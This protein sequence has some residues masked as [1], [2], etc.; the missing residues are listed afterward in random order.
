MLNLTIT[1]PERRQWRRAV[2]FVVIFELTSLFSSV[3]IVD[4]KQ[5]NFG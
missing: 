4:F 3:Y 2:V 5:A 1:I